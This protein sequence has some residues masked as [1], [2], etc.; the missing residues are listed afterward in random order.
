MLIGFTTQIERENT[1]EPRALGL[2]VKVIQRTVFFTTVAMILAVLVEQPGSLIAQ[3]IP[4]S[5]RPWSGS[6][7]VP[8]GGPIIPIFD[9]WYP[10]ADGTNTLCFGYYSV[11]YEEDLDI[12][13][14]PNNFI[15]P[16]QYDGRQPDY[17]EHIPER[18]FSYRRRYCVLPIQVAE[19]F[20]PDDSVV[21]TLQR[22][23]EEPISVP[24]RMLVPYRLDEP[25]SPGRGDV[26]PEI[27]FEAEGA[28]AMGRTGIDVGPVSAEVGM[29][30]ELEVSVDHPEDEVWVGWAKHQG[31]GPVTFSEQNTMMD[32][33]SRAAT[34]TVHFSE[35]G[36]YLIR[37]QS[38]DD[39][40][41]AFE[42][43]CCWTTA[44]V[45][46]IVE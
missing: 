29:P 9:G 6:V 20:G 31:P 4:V 22:G 34:T 16:S 21:W 44:F 37:V 41:E 33:I 18:P 46:V 12:P 42:F 19:D 45:E 7:L 38:I 5:A 25:T 30:L 28:E 40:V 32:P 14:G 26:A 11:N 10:N 36:E 23:R 13:L 8:S 17:F 1:L 27:R 3:E 39:P 15:E 43:H 24:G 2:R 35:P